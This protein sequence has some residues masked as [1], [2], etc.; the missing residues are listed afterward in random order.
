MEVRYHAWRSVETIEN[1]GTLAELKNW[2]DTKSFTFVTR[3]DNP[4]GSV[5]VVGL[6]YEDN[7][8]ACVTGGLLFVCN[9]APDSEG[10]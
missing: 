4:P 2:G 3:N 1:V 6:N 5:T 9:A 8:D 10:R 7:S